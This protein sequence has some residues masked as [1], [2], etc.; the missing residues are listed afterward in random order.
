M[1]G[2]HKRA[3]VVPLRQE[4]RAQRDDR[5]HDVLRHRQRGAV[6]PARAHTKPASPCA[7]KR[8]SSLY[9]QFAVHPVHARELRD[10]ATLAQMRLDQIPTD[11]H[12]ETPS[13]WCL[14]CLDTSIV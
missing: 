4:L 13:A 3:G 2:Q 14:R 7:R 10:R 5:V 9:S 12:P 11:V 1:I 6:Q 8:A